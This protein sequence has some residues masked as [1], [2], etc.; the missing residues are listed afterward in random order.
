MA[1]F[2]SQRRFP[3]FQV[4]EQDDLAA[5]LLDPLVPIQM[6][7]FSRGGCLF[8]IHRADARIIPP[9]KVKLVVNW[10]GKAMELEAEVIYVK[11]IQY[12]GF[13]SLQYGAQFKSDLPEA[14][15]DLE[16]LASKGRILRI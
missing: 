16:S 12:G 3:R 8:Q 2:H 11:P 4:A 15:I 7:H 5:C 13:M 14:T 10:G 9:Q 1:N 6:M